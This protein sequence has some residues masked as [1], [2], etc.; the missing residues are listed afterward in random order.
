MEAV[1]LMTVGD[2]MTVW[3]PGHLAYERATGSRDAKFSGTLT[4]EIELLGF[5][6]K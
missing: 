6:S 2:Q 4:F 3:I 5:T 1:Q